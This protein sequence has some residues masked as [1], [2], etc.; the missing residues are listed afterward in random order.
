MAKAK[1]S[2]SFLFLFHIL[3]FTA[4]LE[5]SNSQPAKAPS[6]DFIKS[7]C[8]S[9]HYPALC[10]QCLSG[11]A[12]SVQ[13]DPRQLARAALQVSLARASAAASHI[14]RLSRLR[15]ITPRESQAVQDCVQNVGHSVSRLSQAIDELGQMGGQAAAAAA[16]DW[17]MSNAQ[18]WVSGAL[19]DENTCLDGFARPGMDGAAKKAV[20]GQVLQLA[21]VV[22]NALA[23]VDRYGSRHRGAKGQP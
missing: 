23:L 14:G 18:T 13:Q 6:T 1:P 10:V 2:L 17:H 4:L 21:Q 22:S 15:G 7:S 9:T 12:A 5:P 19:T 3:F 11:Y 8:R 16:F 20:Q